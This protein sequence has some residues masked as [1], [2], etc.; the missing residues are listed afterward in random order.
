MRKADPV[1]QGVIRRTHSTG[2]PKTRPDRQGL[3]DTIRLYPIPEIGRFLAEAAG[4]R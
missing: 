4:L 3:P 1:A 2:K